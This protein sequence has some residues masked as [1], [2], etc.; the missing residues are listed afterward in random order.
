MRLYDAKK[1]LYFLHI[2]RTGGVV[3]WGWLREMS[4]NRVRQD[5]RKTGGPRQIVGG[6]FDLTVGRGVVQ[7]HPEAEQFMTIFR[8]PFNRL[9]SLYFFIKNQ[10]KGKAPWEPGPPIRLKDYGNTLAGFLDS[11]PSDVTRFLPVGSLHVRPLPRM[12]EDFI[13]VGIAERSRNCLRTLARLVHKRCPMFRHGNPCGRVD[14]PVT[15][16]MRADFHRRH[17]EDYDLYD[18]AC[19]TSASICVKAVGKIGAKKRYVR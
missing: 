12:L 10:Y 13:F 16:C 9:V 4:G 17:P 7:L 6:H 15:P 5:T 19:E 14:E 3:M 1:P 11:Y 18:W 2:P 8:D